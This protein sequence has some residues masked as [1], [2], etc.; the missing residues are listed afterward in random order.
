MVKAGYLGDALKTFLE[1]VTD[2]VD[3]FSETA[4]AVPH[5]STR[6]DEG[7]AKIWALPAPTNPV[8]RL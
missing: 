6:G 7:A 4:H 8:Q 2:G 3:H 1:P 5:G